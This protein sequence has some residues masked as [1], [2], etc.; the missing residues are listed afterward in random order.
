VEFIKLNITNIENNR[1]DRQR[2]HGFSW[3]NASCTQITV[4]FS[5]TVSNPGNW[6]KYAIRRQTVLAALFAAVPLQDHWAQ[7][8]SSL[9][10]AAKCRSA[11]TKHYILNRQTSL[12]ANIGVNEL[13]GKPTVP[14]G[15]HGL[16]ASMKQILSLG[17]PHFRHTVSALS[18]GMFFYMR[19]QIL[20]YTSLLHFLV[21]A[22]NFVPYGGK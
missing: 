11:A 12:C 6:D 18:F 21:M 7:S 20:Q 2:L 17:G 13:P 9:R 8:S 5:E 19:C 1:K 15:I 22:I 14:N 16:N 10:I 4:P 3:S